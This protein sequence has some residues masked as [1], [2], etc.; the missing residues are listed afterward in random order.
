MVDVSELRL[1]LS[2]AEYS[3]GWLREML[4]K[5]VASL[6][7]ATG[8]FRI[9]YSLGI[10]EES[11]AKLFRQVY[12]KFCLGSMMI[13]GLAGTFY[14]F[15]HLI[16]MSGLTEAL[17]A[18]SNGGST[19]LHYS[20]LSAAFLHIYNGFGQA[21]VSSLVGLLGTLLLGFVDQV[22]VSPARTSFFHQWVYLAHE[23]EQR[24]TRPDVY[25]EA[26]ETDDLKIQD[27]APPFA[28]PPII[29]SPSKD[30][31]TTSDQWEILIE[32]LQS[33]KAFYDDCVS[34]LQ[35]NSK[36]QQEGMQN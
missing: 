21:F 23:W 26:S 34:S 20:E 22:F 11:E 29:N 31:V 33:S 12:V 10:A 1:E 7:I 30:D 18:I 4:K 17:Q 6:G 5:N 19:S 16:T 14:S 36:T 28:P 24:L 25:Q 15:V 9:E 32:S 2:R 27:A 3:K 8:A 35:E 13:I